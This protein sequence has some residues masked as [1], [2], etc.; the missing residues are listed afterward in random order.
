MEIRYRFILIKYINKFKMV[1][2]YRKLSRFRIY[3]EMKL[4]FLIDFLYIV[5]NLKLFVDIVNKEIVR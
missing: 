2:I 5:V 4:I 3:S 1:N